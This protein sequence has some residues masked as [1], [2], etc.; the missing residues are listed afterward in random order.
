MSGTSPVRYPDQSS[1]AIMTKRAWWLVGLNI[2]IPGS[3][4]LLAGNRR[5]GRFGV[6]MTFLLWALVIVAAVLWFTWRTP[7]YTLVTTTI[8]LWAIALVLGFYS[9]LWF[10]LTLDTLRLVRLVRTDTTARPFVAG[11]AVLA[12]VLVSGTSAYG[13]YVAVTANAFLSDEFISAPPAEPVD[14]RYNFMLVGGDSGEDRDGLRPDSMTVVSVDATTGEAAMI[15]VPRNMMYAPFPA[16]SPMAALYPNGYGWEGCEVDVCQLN[17]IYTEVELYHQDLYPDAAANGS[18]PGLEATRD[19]LEGISGLT[20]QYYV[21]VDMQGFAD[22]VDALGG[23]TI[24]VENP[25]PIHTDETFTE[26]LEW[27]GP[28]VV[29][30]N[31]YYALWYARSRHDTND[32]DRMARQRQLMEAVLEQFT[33]A[34]LLTKFQEVATASGDLVKTDVSQAALGYFVDLASKSRDLPITQFGL[35]PDSGVDPEDPQYD[36]IHELV[37]SVTAPP[38]EDDSEE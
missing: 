36:Y 7:L 12:L 2:L 20:I 21:L 3:A 22:L 18:S 6:S 17:S 33:P 35:D 28:G 13:A 14:G 4:Q 5:L 11:L 16:D 26:V 24:T 34:N 29:H 38:P 31:G 19:A 8:G 37:A 10:I 15:G 25:V 1:P 32:Y 23:V 30:L 9:V 27:I